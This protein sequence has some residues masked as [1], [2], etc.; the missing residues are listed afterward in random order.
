[1]ANIKNKKR[2]KKNNTM[3]SSNNN[4]SSITT[5]PVTTKLNHM[6]MGES[7]SLLY[8][9]AAR[10]LREY[11]GV[12]SMTAGSL[13]KTMFLLQLRPGRLVVQGLA[14]KKLLEGETTI[15]DIFESSTSTTSSSSDNEDSNQ[16]DRSTEDGRAP[17]NN[18]R[19]IHGTL[20]AAGVKLRPRE[21][22]PLLRALGVRPHR[23]V[24][25]GLVQREALLLSRP[26][27][28]DAPA[29]VA[30]AVGMSRPDGPC[31]HAP[32][33]HGHGR[34]PANGRRRCRSS[35][36]IHGPPHGPFH[37][38]TGRPNHSGRTH[39]GGMY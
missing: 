25:L 9:M 10:N 30:T 2:K 26:G 29:D 12:P 3:R 28:R 16:D 15:S 6:R 18:K 32:P 35:S 37:G 17:A 7:S 19:P 1:M 33:P 11:H 39:G 34:L 13:E 8:Q 21:T 22:S 23:L 27:G 5:G 24:K 4:D 20:I 38:A 14:S 31:R 36:L